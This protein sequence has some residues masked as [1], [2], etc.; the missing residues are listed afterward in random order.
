MFGIFSTREISIA[1]W[2][3]I[4]VLL[5]LLYKPTRKCVADLFKTACSVQLA[6]PF[7]LMIGYAAG[8]TY[9]FSKTPLWRMLFIKDIV[10]WVIFVGTPLFF[11]S[12]NKKVEEHY[13][14]KAM[15]SN[16][17][18]MVLVEFFISSFTLPLIWEMLL[19][20]IMTFLFM[21]DAVAA[22]DSQYRPAKKLVGFVII[23]INI[24][25]IIETLS[26]AA[27]SLST[28]DKN[29]AII[30]LFIP[31]VFS[32]LYVPASYIFAVFG[33]YQMVFIRMSF[34]EPKEHFNIRLAH[35]FKV[36]WSC[37]LSLARLEQFEKNYIQNMFVGMSETEFE[38]LVCDF[39]TKQSANN[40]SAQNNTMQKKIV[41]E[42]KES[43]FRAFID[44]IN[45]HIGIF[46][47]L[48]TLCVG[49]LSVILK[50]F[51]Y[52]FMCG[53]LDYWGIDHSY[54]D[55]SNENLLY[56]IVLFAA[57]AVVFIAINL[58]PFSI[59]TSKFTWY[60]K[61]YKT[62]LLII[63][64]SFVFAAIFLIGS[65]ILKEVSLAELFSV[66]IASMAHL[67]LE[68]VIQSIPVSLVVYSMGLCMSIPFIKPKSRINSRIFI[69][70]IFS[71]ATILPLILGLALYI[72]LA[73]NYGK[74]SASEQKVF[75]VMGDCSV[76]IYEDSEHYIV[77]DCVIIGDKM[78]INNAGQKLI[79]KELTKTVTT[80]FAIVERK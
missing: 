75:K 13:F 52:V 11:G 31:I 24:I 9:L 43:N 74:S 7:F 27:N 40:L 33:K 58:I 8:I 66:P 48:T 19:I 1:I 35:R 42:I 39:R 77:S 17:K 63:V 53:K 64:T 79:S 62:T 49:L 67:L 78:T 54:I 14:K 68:L 10:V 12:L 51:F 57:I 18:L 4:F 72:V 61:L 80:T 55:V 15:Q 29:T 46:T 44:Y 65:L 47:L 32:I 5:I 26:V 41:N 28:F 69:H 23:V 30:S 16:F 2:L 50:C 22:T 70:K 3:A 6:I 56:E 60:M 20:P 73:Y 38:K 21:L 45:A 37:G 71:I 25:F 34:K 36:I 76:V 59:L